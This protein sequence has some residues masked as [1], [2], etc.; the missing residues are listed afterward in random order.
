[1]TERTIQLTADG[2]HTIFVPQLG[3]HYHSIH[4]SIAESLHVFIENGLNRTTGEE[5]NILEVGFGTGLNALLTCL[6]CRATGRRARYEAWEKYPLLPG[7]YEPLNYG[8]LLRAD[9]SLLQRIHKAPWESPC[10]I[11]EELVLTKKLGD[12][13]SFS[14][15][16]R[17]GLVYFDA[18]GPDV[19][20]LLWTTEV[21]ARIA[22]ALEEDAILVTYSVKGLVRRNLKEAGF[23]VI[24]VPGPKGKREMTVAYR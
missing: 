23:R 1:M 17:F 9:P 11:D 21:F 10:R 19:Q 22:G 18:F 2:S 4:G 6:A 8:K 15:E 14:S 5:V 24:K 16:S 3:E 20:P 7:E 13:R 12:I